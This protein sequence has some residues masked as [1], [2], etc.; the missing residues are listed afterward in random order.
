MKKF[1]FFLLG[2]ILG[3]AIVWGIAISMQCNTETTP[4]KPTQLT[5]QSITV[6]RPIANEEIS[7]PISIEGTAKGTWFFEAVA[8]VKI[9]DEKGLELGSGS[10]QAMG[11]WMTEDFVPFKGKISFD[12]KTSKTGFLI[13]EKSNPSGL[14][15]NAEEFKLPVNFQ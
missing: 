15:E 1:I 8:P 6:T 2:L 7:P 4:A 11:D 3:M 13:F 10:L 9:V 12:K 5:T 14:K